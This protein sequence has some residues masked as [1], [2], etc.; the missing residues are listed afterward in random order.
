[1][2]RDGGDLD[3]N[4]ELS[5]FLMNDLA[6]TFADTQDDGFFAYSVLAN[7]AVAG[8]SISESM[9]QLYLGPCYEIAN[10]NIILN[11]A[12]Y[13]HGAG[14]LHIECDC[15]DNRVLCLVNDLENNECHDVGAEAKNT[16]H[17]MYTQAV[18]DIMSLRES[19]F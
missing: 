2:T 13:F 14:I 9:M 10:R 15:S 3:I 1:M 4:Q 7:I 16:G 18:A 11:N 6:A 8:S 5:E 17:P 12:A 19:L